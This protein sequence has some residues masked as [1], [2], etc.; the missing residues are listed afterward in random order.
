MNLRIVVSNMTSS[1][2]SSPYNITIPFMTFSINFLKSGENSIS[3]KSKSGSRT[4]PTR[5]EI[6]KHQCPFI[7]YIES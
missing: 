1:K 3:A 2:V 4:T 6:K 5:E 7:K